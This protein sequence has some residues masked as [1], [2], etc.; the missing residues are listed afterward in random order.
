MLYQRPRPMLPLRHRLLLPARNSLTA[1]RSVLA[2][3]IVSLLH[4]EQKRQS[5]RTASVLLACSVILA[6]AHHRYKRQCRPLH[7]DAVSLACLFTSKRHH[8][9]PAYCM[10]QCWLAPCFMRK[11]RSELQAKSTDVAD[12]SEASGTS[13]MASGRAP[14]DSIAVTASSTPVS[15]P[16]L[17]SST[18]GPVL[19]L[20]VMSD[21]Q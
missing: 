1:P 3:I 19:I 9:L 17:G 18:S 21:S 16:I 11:N 5:G 2:C 12:G 15:I 7:Q 8:L 4:W 10:Q 13:G 14:S 6:R 20:N